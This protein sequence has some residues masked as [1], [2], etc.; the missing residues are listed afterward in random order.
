MS[1]PI[2][3]TQLRRDIYRILDHVLETGKSQ[4][5]ERNGQRLV[6]LP[7]QPRR[8]LSKIPKRKVMNCTFDE[9]VNT[10]WADA[11]EPDL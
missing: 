1:N 9:L 6:L 5:I 8:D 4:E 2:K 11:W 7:A 10:S 3:A